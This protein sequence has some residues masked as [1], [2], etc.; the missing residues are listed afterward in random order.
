M[1]KQNLLAQG[2]ISILT[3]LDTFKRNGP[4][5]SLLNPVKDKFIAKHSKVD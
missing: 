5:T 2:K 3:L 4:G 1:V